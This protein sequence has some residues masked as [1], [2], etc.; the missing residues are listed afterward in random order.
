MKVERRELM[1]EAA[2]LARL[3]KQA[4]AAGDAALVVAIDVGIDEVEAALDE[5]DDVVPFNDS[6]TGYDEWPEAEE[7]MR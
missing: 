2:L 4:A 1:A 3:R 7:D 5:L 6:K